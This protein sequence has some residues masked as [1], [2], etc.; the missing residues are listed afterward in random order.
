MFV[1]SVRRNCSEAVPLNIFCQWCGKESPASAW[2]QTDRLMLL[3][4]IPLFRWSNVLVQ[5]Q[6]CEREFLAKCSLSELRSV[7]PLTLQH[8]L[9]KRVSFVAKA[10]AVLGLLLC[11]APLIGMI[12]STIAFIMTRRQPGW[13]AKV[14]VIGFFISIV[15]TVVPLAAQFFVR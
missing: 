3:H 6:S 1:Y 8:L 4:L 7:S 2:T 11:W 15:T 10:C 5:C 9:V 13:V 14:S 12:P